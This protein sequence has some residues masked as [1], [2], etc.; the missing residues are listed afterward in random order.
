M[1]RHM[2]K[3]TCNLCGGTFSKA[4]MTKRLKSCKPTGG[5]SGTSSPGRSPRKIKTFHIVVEGRYLPDYWI[6]LDVPAEGTLEMLLP[7]VNSPRV[8]VCAYTGD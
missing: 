8:G 6:H 3:G 2:S 5:A 7:V 1:A 4:A